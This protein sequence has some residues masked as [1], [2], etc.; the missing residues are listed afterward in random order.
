MKHHYLFLL[1][2]AMLCAPDLIAND[3]I[4][5]DGF[6]TRYS[7]T[8]RYIPVDSAFETRLQER[9][10]RPVQFLY[11]VDFTTYFDNREYRS[12]YQIPQTIFNFRLSPEIGVRILDRAGGRHELVAG[13]SYTKRLG[14]DWRD[15]QFDP[16]AYYR[17]RYRGF[18]VGLGAIPYT[19]RIA[20]MPDWLLY[21]SVAYM[22][23]NIQGAHMAYQD[24]RGF[25]ELMCDWRGAQTPER[26]EMFRVLVN[27][28]Y[29][30]KW[31]QAGGLAHLNHK[32]SFASPNHEY[33]MD[34]IHLNGFVGADLTRYTP[35]DSLSV[36]AG[37]IFGWQRDRSVNE[38]FFN[39]G[40]LIELYANWWFIGLKN[41]LYVGDNMQPLRPRNAYLCLGDPF[42]QSRLYNRTDIFVYLYRASF[43]NV[44]FSWNMHYDTHRLQ[45]QQQVI[46]RFELE[47]LMHQ[48]A[49]SRQVYL[50]GMFDK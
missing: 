30:Y 27:G 26:R 47:P 39:H 1:L 28:Q 20:A 14:G 46:V 25:V 49:G 24:E 33:V 6:W 16:I 4:K 8:P 9:A 21:D 18:T 37:Y 22:H 40:A 35:L 36:R 11:D 42:Y 32:A 15:V 12:P 31:L 17:F 29:R 41:T 5:A 2:V 43:V 23:P 13:V 38:S 10:N 19:Q 44:Y 48:L 45:H 50:R 34:D 3:S 7:R